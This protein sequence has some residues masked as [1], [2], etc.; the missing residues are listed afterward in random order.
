M[1]AL[2]ILQSALTDSVF[3]KT[4]LAASAKDLWDMLEYLPEF[5]LLVL[6]PDDMKFDEDMWMICSSASNH[7]TSYYKYFT[8]LDRTYRARARFITG[9]I[10]MVQGMGDVSIMTK[11]GSRRRSRLCFTFRR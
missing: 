7:M 1:K 2:Q 8:T 4:L 10:E 6:Y 5:E 11:K 9:D 3:R